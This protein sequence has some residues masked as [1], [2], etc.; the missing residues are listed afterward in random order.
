MSDIRLLL[1]SDLLPSKQN[2]IAGTFIIDRMKILNAKNIDVLPVKL[3]NV[4]YCRRIM[5]DYSLNFDFHPI[6]FK[7]VNYVKFRYNGN[8]EL[9]A[10]KLYRLYKKYNR[11]LVHIHFGFPEGYIGYILKRKYGIKYILTVHGSD[12]H[13]IPF[14]NIHYKDKIMKG[15]NHADH[16]IFV[17]NYLLEIALKLGLK[18]SNYSVIRGG[19]D[20]GIFKPFKK[21]DRKNLTISYVG[22][23][24]PIKGTDIIPKIFYNITKY[25]D[26]VRLKI[27][28]NGSLREQI[29]RDLKRLNI[30]D[31]AYLTGSIPHGKIPG[32]LKETDILILPSIHEGLSS[33]ILESLASGIPVVATSTGGIPEIIKNGY[34][35][36]LIEKGKDFA[37]RFS[38]GV[39]SALDKEWNSKNIRNSAIEFDW[40]NVV[41]KEIEVYNRILNL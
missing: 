29:E 26:N 24:E 40:Q 27:I 2:P 32:E 16:V 39:L 30:F 4:L 6:N 20:T 12:L 37:K 1:F 5:N 15:L 3:S 28:G 11:N 17:S 38:F 13:T 10:D 25:K 23:L 21:G 22:H 9:V 8:F 18:N 19:V 14:K 7:V 36:I 31:K 35:G 33:V 34:N 41:T